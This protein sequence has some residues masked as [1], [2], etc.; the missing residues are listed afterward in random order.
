MRSPTDT[1]ILCSHVAAIF[2]AHANIVKRPTNLEVLIER[3]R[4][5]WGYPDA[6]AVTIGRVLQ[7]HGYNFAG[8]TQL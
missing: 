7:H 3:V 4:F 1:Y 5:S 2:F 8:H 6:D